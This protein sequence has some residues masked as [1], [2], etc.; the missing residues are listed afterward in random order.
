[1][2]RRKRRAKISRARIA[3]WVAA[4]CPNVSPQQQDRLVDVF[5][6]SMEKGMT[7]EELAQKLE[8]EGKFYLALKEIGMKK[9]LAKPGATVG[10]VLTEKDVLKAKLIATT[11]KGGKSD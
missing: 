4:E 9:G 5:V 2:W 7:Q 11:I 1:M 3:E 6:E 10:E 8:Q